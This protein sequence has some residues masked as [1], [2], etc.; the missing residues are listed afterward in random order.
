MLRYEYENWIF[1]A[2]TERRSKMADFGLDACYHSVAFS[3]EK[4]Q[5]KPV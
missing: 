1:P 4:L 2:E 5:K 3:V